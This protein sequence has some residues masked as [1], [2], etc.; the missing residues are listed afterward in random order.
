M[1]HLWTVIAAVVI[2]PIAWLLLAYG[3]DRSVQAFANGESQGVLQ[4]GD[5]LRPVVCLAAAGLLFGL[6][7]TLRFSPL[8][9]VLTGAV[10]TAG[11]LGLLVNPNALIDVLPHRI[12]LAGRV[13]DPTTP[14]RT[15]SA[16]VLGA[17]LL[18][19][20]ASIG[21]WRRWPRRPT[22]D[23][24]WADDP[25]PAPAERPLGVDGLGLAPDR[26]AE[27]SRT[28]EAFWTSETSSSGNGWRGGGWG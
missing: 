25:L 18:V 22:T 8:G 13:A 4:T 12:S 1:R 5:F 21:R 23:Q 26:Y 15:G 16:L 2:A 10:Y 24:D 19:G 28:D 27:P 3:Q 14:I 7:A 17:L 6:L 11:Y 9:A 20:V